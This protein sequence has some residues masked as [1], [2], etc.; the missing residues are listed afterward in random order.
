MTNSPVHKPYY[1]N[2]YLLIGLLFTAYLTARAII[3]P[4]TIDEAGTYF[5]YTPLKVWDIIF[6]TKDSSP[7]NH[8]LN[9]LGIKLFTQLFGVTSFTVRLTNLLAFVLYFFVGVELLKKIRNEFWFVLCGIF[10]LVCNPY[11][12]DFFALA[13]GYGL[14]VGL[15][16]LS[17]YQFYNY[18]SQKHITYLTYTIITAALAVLANFTLLN[19]YLVLL[20]LTVVI[21]FSEKNKKDIFKKILPL[22]L[23]TLVLAALIYNPIKKMVSTDQF[24]YWGTESFYKSTLLPLVDAMRYSKL[25]FGIKPATYFAVIFIVVFVALGVYS[26]QQFIKHKVKAVSNFAVICFLILSGIIVVTILQFHLF[27]VPFLN[28][29]GA[30]FMYPIFVLIVIITISNIFINKQR[31][32]NIVLSVFFCIGLIH[33]FNTA[34]FRFYRDWWFDAHTKDVLT[35]IDEQHPQKEKVTLNCSW[36]FN[37]SLHFH[38]DVSNFYNLELATFNHDLQ[39]EGNYQY[40]YCQRGDVEALSKNYVELFS[41]HYGEF[42]LMQHK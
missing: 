11:L 25:Y 16:L 12:L 1:D 6:Y 15:M 8:V 17:I 5:N 37:N 10:I 32:R 29:R 18:L 30:V 34:N 13:R 33:F 31:Q 41:Y 24:V 14:S 39:P 7:N 28:A 2:I 27:D 38:K 22:V 42:V 9:T 23:T 36:I 35:W 4:M 3:I 21:I 19:Y 20:F 26:A 40:Y